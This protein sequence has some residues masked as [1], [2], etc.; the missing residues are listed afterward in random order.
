MEREE[1]STPL[2]TEA[3]ERPLLQTLD[4]LLEKFRPLLRWLTFVSVLMIISGDVF[5]YSLYQAEHARVEML[6][7]RVGRLET[8]LVEA[9]NAKENSDK[10]KQIESQVQGIEDDV[11]DVADFLKE[12]APKRKKRRRR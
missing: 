5:L 7:R 10:L 4:E 2:N 12:D 8:M 11:T 3:P 9:I 6:N 1:T